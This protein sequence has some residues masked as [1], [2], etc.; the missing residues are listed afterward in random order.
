MDCETCQYLWFIF[1]SLQYTYVEIM[2]SVT[3]NLNTDI[4]KFDE[5]CSLLKESE[6]QKSVVME[7]V[8]SEISDKVL[9]VRYSD[10]TEI[11]P[12]LCV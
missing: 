6:L 12:N 11:C 9:N 2:H 1:I 7:V 3:D 8:A 4:S 5:Y 10:A